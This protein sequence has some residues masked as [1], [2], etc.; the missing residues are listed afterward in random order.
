MAW[1]PI[2]T[3]PREEAREIL[4]FVPARG[5]EYHHDSVLIVSWLAALESWESCCG[6]VP[7]DEPTHW[8]PLPEPPA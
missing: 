2:A 6:A 3:A 7:P 8:Q 4:I 5:R 1:Q